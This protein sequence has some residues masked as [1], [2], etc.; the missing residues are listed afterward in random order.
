MNL[1]IKL[2]F[3][4]MLIF[5]S[6]LAFAQTDEGP[7]PPPPGEPETPIDH[8]LVYLVILGSLLAFYFFK[9]SELLHK[10]PVKP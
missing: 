8:Y 5:V 1:K 9:K 4:W 3:A 7:D 6:G 2:C 10:K